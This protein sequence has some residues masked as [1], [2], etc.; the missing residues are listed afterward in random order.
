ME[1]GYSR[2]GETVT[3][4]MSNADY[5]E[6]LLCLGYSAGAVSATPRSFWS[7]IGL[8]N[9]LNAGNPQFQPYEIPEEFR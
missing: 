3:I 1:L 2:E 9:R 4:R 5:Q 6:L 8:T 7:R